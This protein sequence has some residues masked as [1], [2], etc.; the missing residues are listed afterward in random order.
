M[1]LKMKWTFTKDFKL[2]TKYFSRLHWEQESWYIINIFFL[3]VLDFL[4]SHFTLHNFTMRMQLIQSGYFVVDSEHSRSTLLIPPVNE[5]KVLVNYMKALRTI[6]LPLIASP[7]AAL[8]SVWLSVHFFI[9]KRL[10]HIKKRSFASH[11][12]CVN[13]SR[14]TWK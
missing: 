14:I 2:K 9:N 4:L 3:V 5:F 7:Y 10:S 13:C 6:Y 1:T 11:G 12:F 8:L